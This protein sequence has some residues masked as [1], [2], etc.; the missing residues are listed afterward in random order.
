MILDKLFGGELAGPG[1][2]RAAV[3]CSISAH[4]PLGARFLAADARTFAAVG[5]HP[6]LI[7][8][9]VRARGPQAGFWPIPGQAVDAQLA[10]AWATAPP[11]AVKVGAVETVDAVT[12]VRGALGDGPPPVVLDPEIIDKAG[13]RIAPD[14]VAEALKTEI[15]GLSQIVVL[16][17]YEAALWGERP[18]RGAESLREAMKAVYDLGAPWVVG[19]AA[20]EERHAV[21]WVFDGSGFIEFGADRVESP[22]LAGSGAVFSSALAAHLARGS[23]VLPAIEQAKELATTAVRDGAAVAAGMGPA[24]PLSGLYRSAGI[25]FAAISELATE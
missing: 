3:A 8:C 4:D 1:P 24:N 18:V 23:D 11:D 16:N 9:G 14:E 12:L 13:V 20:P 10:A 19:H 2:R 7:A 25:D 6:V 21:D 17:V 22:F 5:V 15:L